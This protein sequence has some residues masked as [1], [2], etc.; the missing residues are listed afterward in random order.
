M[1]PGQLFAPPGVVGERKARSQNL[2]LERKRTSGLHGLY[3]E[4]LTL[5]RGHIVHVGFV[6]AGFLDVAPHVVHEAQ[7]GQKPCQEVWDG[8][9]SRF[10][11]P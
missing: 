2:V 5:T 1:L 6:H 11:P 10:L 7:H 3:L 4:I 9:N 8:S